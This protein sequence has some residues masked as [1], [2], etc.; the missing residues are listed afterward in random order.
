M[1]LLNREGSFNVFNGIK[2]KI[3]ENGVKV[4]DLV[5]SGLD[6]YPLW[7]VC[8]GRL[9]S[10]KIWARQESGIKIGDIG[11]VALAITPKKRYYVFFLD[12]EASSKAREDSV[13]VDIANVMSQS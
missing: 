12:K 1:I 3:I 9:K 4:V 11:T 6:E 7:M 8:T 10:Y 5:P 13:L 2:H